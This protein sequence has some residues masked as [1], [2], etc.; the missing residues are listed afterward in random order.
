MALSNPSLA[1]SRVLGSAAIVARPPVEFDACALVYTAPSTRT[2]R[3][4]P[5][6]TPIRWTLASVPPGWQAGL[7]SGS[8]LAIRLAGGASSGSRRVVTAVLFVALFWRQAVDLA[9]RLVE[10]SGGR[11]RA[12]AR[13]R[14]HLAGLAVGDSPGRRA[15]PR[16]RSHVIVARRGHSL[17][18]GPGRR[19]VLDARVDGHGARRADDLHFGFRQLIRWWLPFTLACLAIP[20]PELVTQALALPLQFRASKMG[21]A[22]LQ[23][24]QVPGSAYRQRHPAAGTRALRHRGLQRTSVAHG[25]PERRRVDERAA[26][27]RRSSAA[28]A[29]RRA[30][31][32]DRDR[33]QR[34]PRVHDRIPRLFRQ[35]G[36]RKRLHAPDRRLAAV[37]S[38]RSRR[39]RLLRVDWLSMIERRVRLWRRAAV[40]GNA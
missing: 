29:L 1:H 18:R 9:S 37:S 21:A 12:A 20:L 23:M 38:S 14:R 26:S 22:L 24:R 5:T 19:A 27:S 15:E 17:R 32:P 16:R 13:A 39:S 34:H 8:P 33:R 36:I 3:G 28:C 11:A 6:Q 31:D 25:A 40:V 7:D 4:T 30:R 35:P 10:R 2:S